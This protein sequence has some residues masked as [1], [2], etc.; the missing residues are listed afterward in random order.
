M[1]NKR[2]NSNS[3]NSSDK[4]KDFLEKEFLDCDLGDIPIPKAEI[5]MYESEVQEVMKS[6]CN[7]QIAEYALIKYNE[8]EEEEAK[9]NGEEYKKLSQLREEYAK[10]GNY[11]NSLAIEG[12]KE[13]L[14]KSIDKIKIDDDLD[15]YEDEIN[16][17]LSNPDIEKQIQD[18]IKNKKISE[19]DPQKI[20]KHYLKEKIKNYDKENLFLETRK[21][22]IEKREAVIEFALR[23]VKKIVN[24]EKEYK[25]FYKEYYG[26]EE[27]EEEKEEEKKNLK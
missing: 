25:K 22:F 4:E 13:Y 24:D 7:R 18:K 17:I 27:K 11:V 19:E 21:N 12:I 14:D 3:S 26:K 9:Q 20:A 1:S 23:T 5:E 2:K 6:G 16:E 8:I 10:H 15:G